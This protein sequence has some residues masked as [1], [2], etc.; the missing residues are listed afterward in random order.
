MNKDL[1][2]LLISLSLLFITVL[3][4]YLTT[5]YSCHTVKYQNLD[6]THSKEVCEKV[7]K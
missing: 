1:K 2:M 5:N 6:G 7:E 4:I 3:Y